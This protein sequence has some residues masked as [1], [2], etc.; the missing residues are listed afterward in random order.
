MVILAALP[1]MERE[2][3]VT[4]DLAKPGNF[5]ATVNFLGYRI[6]QV[7]LGV[8]L[9]EPSGWSP[10]HQAPQGDAPCRTLRSSGPSGNPCSRPSPGRSLAPASA[11]SLSGS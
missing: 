5:S 4:G 1:G 9:A 3:P 6:R 10:S 7:G 8:S 2:L 11:A